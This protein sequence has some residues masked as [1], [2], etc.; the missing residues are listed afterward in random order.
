MDAQKKPADPTDWP[1]RLRAA[2]MKA[3]APRLAVL[4]VLAD[5]P[6]PLGVQEIVEKIAEKSADTATVYRIISAFVEAGFVRN[7]AVRH[8]H[9][10]YEL[11]GPTDHH[12][13]VCL[14]CGRI[15][16][17][18]ECDVDALAR[19]VLKNSSAF[20]EVTQHSLE[21]FGRCKSCLKKE[22]GGSDV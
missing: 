19:S 3:T 21:L 17:F 6:H 14:V 1:A 4:S 20:G 11:V 7:V 8:N 10:D 13:L 12:H 2:G 18:E 15:E 22:K 16:D 9:S 5:S